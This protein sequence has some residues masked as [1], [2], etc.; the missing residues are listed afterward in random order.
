M[1]TRLIA[2]FLLIFVNVG[3]AA[4]P[5]R[6]LRRV[7]SDSGLPD[8]NVRNMIML[9]S[10]M[11]CIQ[12]ST[13][14]NLYDGTSSKSY[15]FNPVEIPYQEY[16]G[17]S[18]IFYENNSLWFSYHDR[19]WRFDLD[20]REFEY[21]LST[22]LSPFETHE[23]G[24]RSYYLASDGSRWIVS[25]DGEL[26]CRENS[27]DVTRTEGKKSK[28]TTVAARRIEKP[29]G[30]TAPLIMTNIGSSV[31]M[32]SLDGTLACYDCR[33]RSFTKLIPKIA[34][35][36]SSRIEMTA[37]S[38]GDLWMLFDKELVRLKVESGSVEQIL[39][40]PD[41]NSDDV[42]TTF[43]IDRS[44]CLWIGSSKSGVRILDTRT[45]VLEN[46]PHLELTDGQTIDHSTDISK[47]YIDPND[48]VWVA[49]LT[50]GVFY[51]HKDIFR[52]QTVNCKTLD[53]STFPDE[54]VKCLVE[55]ADGK[56]LLGTVH[57]LLRYDPLSGRVTIP[58]PEL[59]D[60][61]CTGL[62]RDS[63]NRIWLGT[64]R[65]GAF[66]I[67]RGHIRHY[68]YDGMPSVE[69]SYHDATPNLNSVRTFYEDSEGKFWICVYG[70]LGRFDPRSGRIHLLRET[71][72]ELKGFMLMRGVCEAGG[73]LIVTS[74]NGRFAYDPKADSLADIDSDEERL[75]CAQ[76]L[77]DG[78]GILWL[79]SSDGLHALLPDETTRRLTLKDG[80]PNDNILGL[81]LDKLGNIWA[82]TFNAVS[83]VKVVETGASAG[84]ADFEFTVTNFGGEDGMHAGTLFPNALIV[85]S[86]GRLYAGGSHGFSVADPSNLY[87]QSSDYKPVITH[88]GIFNKPIEVGEEYNGRCIL[89][90]ELA[91]TEKIVLRHSETFLTFGFSN[92]N[93]INP[94]HT[95]YRYKLENFDKDWTELHAWGAGSATY[96]LL[97]P[98]EYVFT[99]IA[100]DNDT[101]WSSGC[102]ELAVTIR[103]PFYSSVPAKIFYILLAGILAVLAVVMTNRRLQRQAELRRIEE[104]QRQKEEMDQMKFRFFTNISH[105]LRT[106]LSLILLPLESILKHTGDDFQ[107]RGQLLT[108][109][110]HAEEL[111]Q[112]VNH[113]LD[114]RKLDMRGEKLSLSR[115]DIADFIGSLV[116]LFEDTAREKELNIDFDN[117]MSNPMM[118]FDSTKIYK[119]V[120]NLLSNAVKFTP[121]G[122]EIDVRLIQKDEDRMVIE[123]ADTGVGICKDDIDQ[124]FDRFYQSEHNPD[125]RGTGIGLYLVKQYAQMHGGNVTVESELRVG[126]TFRVEI[127]T[128]REAKANDEETAEESR[129]IAKP[130]E[131]NENRRS[132]L[133]ES[134]KEVDE[135]PDKGNRRDRIL[136]IEDNSEFRTYMAEELGH[137]FDISQ[138]SDGENGLRKAFNHVFNIIICDVMMPKMDGF[139]VCRRLKNDINT[140]H[141]PIILLTAHINDDVR[142][143]GYEAGADAYLSKPFSMDILL[144]RIHNLTED[145]RRRI[146][147]FATGTDMSPA[148]ITVTPLDRKLMDKVMECIEKN[149]SNADYSVEELAS[150]VAMHRMSLYRKLRSI[151]GFTPS[152]FIRSMRLKRAARILSQDPSIS[153]T[154]VSEL[155]GFNTPKYFSHYFN[156]AFGCMPSQYRDRNR[157]S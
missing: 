69:V 54:S 152:E 6:L 138:A 107:F 148:E 105:E 85:S 75:P 112:M 30:L 96:T 79:A 71:H 95:R 109:H 37:D 73:R 33:L 42:F 135:K 120:N 133:T 28:Q 111:L 61:L 146:K 110:R 52:L 2:F 48:G 155:V 113:L 116:A 3:A 32:L 27:E 141:I 87:Q 121:K 9:P 35:G 46:L 8:N 106:P 86:D 58:Y 99:V 123:V 104:Q 67:D 11:I 76:A 18:Y 122:G 25:E 1:T 126:S 147:A 132:E 29:E 60:E 80:M 117:R 102:T 127:P 130:A 62:Y 50:E 39:S 41:E 129:L 63:R 7:G 31:W 57:G 4:A 150:D 40:I 115:G 131:S 16:A 5:Q 94:G 139:E 22:L 77:L 38:E 10:G 81:A 72:P 103:P 56:I 90:R 59:E 17:L 26:W 49:T 140:S 36:I 83:R 15:R 93:Y 88:L 45:L 20:T 24:V 51:Y 149:M 154:E 98:G 21:D 108:I 114:F 151:T 118:D 65:N 142:R 19:V 70:G 68:F 34:K 91:H 157:Q 53:N 144:A 136:I 101:D 12:T 78:R 43:A 134:D 156:E 137:E 74:D 92:F 64:F 44:D 14:L 100:A 143:E 23:S 97:S 153:V 13:M 47:I 89:S 119:I 55:E 145:R 84:G 66:C 124:I 82:A 125:H 128:R